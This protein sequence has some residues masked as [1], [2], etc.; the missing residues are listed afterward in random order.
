MLCALVGLAA[1]VRWS[2]VCVHVRLCLWICLALH[3]LIEMMTTKKKKTTMAMV[4]AVVAATMMAMVAVVTMMITIITVM[5]SF[6]GGG[7]N[8]AGNYSSD[9][10][11]TRVDCDEKSDSDNDNSVCMHF[12]ITLFDCSAYQLAITNEDSSNAIRLHCEI[13]F[14]EFID[15]I[16]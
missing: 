4:V 5:S 15:D 6:G 11:N 13:A 8:G 12:S 16:R 3:N 1:T 9:N 10:Y 2:D 14:D 7:Y